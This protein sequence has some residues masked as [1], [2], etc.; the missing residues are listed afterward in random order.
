VQVSKAPI[1]DDRTQHWVA[2]VPK[3]FLVDFTHTPLQQL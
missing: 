1:G 2:Q 3:D